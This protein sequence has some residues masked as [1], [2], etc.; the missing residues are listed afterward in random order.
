MLGN[1]LVA[2]LERK[3]SSEDRKAINME[4]VELMQDFRSLQSEK[5]LSDLLSVQSVSPLRSTSVS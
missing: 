4:N 2:A 5:T 3:S 1:C